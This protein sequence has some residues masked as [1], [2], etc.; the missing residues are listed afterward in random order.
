MIA[1]RRGRRSFE[2]LSGDHRNRRPRRRET[3]CSTDSFVAWAAVREA[4]SAVAIDCAELLEAVDRFVR[5]PALPSS[6]KVTLGSETRTWFEEIETH[7]LT[8][9]KK[10]AESLRAWASLVGEQ[11]PEA[12]TLKSLANEIESALDAVAK[13]GRGLGSDAGLRVAVAR[14]R[15]VDESGFR[16]LLHA[17]ESTE[18]ASPSELLAIVGPDHSP[19]VDATREVILL[20]DGYFDSIERD[21]DQSDRASRG[22]AGVGTLATT[23]LAAIDDELQRLLDVLET[24]P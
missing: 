5:E 3:T 10:E 18:K 19:V 14:L 8:A 1:R 4:E 17:A 24:E 7:L 6:V 21:L 22:S 2:A 23:A 13:A 20:A 12:T 9:P 16:D 11:I 15:S